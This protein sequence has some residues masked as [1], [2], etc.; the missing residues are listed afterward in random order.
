MNNLVN[1]PLSSPTQ[2]TKPELSKRQQTDILR[3]LVK[4]AM[5]LMQHH[6]ESK[7]V[8][9]TTSR[10]GLALGLDSVEMALTDNAV[11][12]TSLY[13][14]RCKT[15]TRRVYDR[16]IN[17]HVVCEIQRLT[18]KAEQQQ[19]TYQQVNELL[20]AITPQKYNRWLLV[21][22]VGLACASFSHLLGGDW[23]VF[24]MTLLASCTAMVFRQEMA[25]RH[26]SL[27]LIFCLTAFVA[28][29]VASQAVQYNIGNQPELVMAA[30]VLLLVP[31]F[32]LINAVSDFLKGYISIG[33]ARWFMATLLSFAVA[34][35]IAMALFLTGTAGW[36]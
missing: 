1:D 10:M 15:T 20:E 3:L 25:R 6:A 36:N 19:L 7:L 2:Q 8:E 9:Q 23:Q 33:I 27:L 16:G 4:L 26:H 32:P 14:G 31:G 34:T 35:G 13:H 22:M 11:I 17:M 24:M 12:I 28:T 21:V 18:L 30:S 29:L 5:R